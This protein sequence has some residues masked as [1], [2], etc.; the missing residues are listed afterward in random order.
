MIITNKPYRDM[1]LPELRK[2]FADASALLSRTTVPSARERVR[3]WQSMVA[4][5]IARREREAGGM[6]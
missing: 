3:G 1:T 2:E 4:K 5:W 6:A